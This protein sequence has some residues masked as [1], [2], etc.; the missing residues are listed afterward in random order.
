MDMLT[1]M[2]MFAFSCLLL[3]VVLLQVRKLSILT[4]QAIDLSPVLNRMDW[5]QSLRDQADRSARDEA[6]RSR[7]E[8]NAQSQ[9]LRTE[10]VSSLTG[11]GDSVSSKV[12][13]FSRLNDQKLELLRSGLEQRLDFFTTESGRKVEGLTQSVIAS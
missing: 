9:G 4:A 10:V 6:A 7:Q 13:G 2:A 1:I 8:Q 3:L 11:I 12:E 5:L